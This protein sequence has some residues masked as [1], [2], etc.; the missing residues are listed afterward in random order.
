VIATCFDFDSH[1]QFS[2]SFSFACLLF[3]TRPKLLSLWH[4]V[5]GRWRAV[6]TL[7]PGLAMQG[8]AF[9]WASTANIER[10]LVAEFGW[11]A[12][13]NQQIHAAITSRATIGDVITLA[14]AYLRST[15]G[16]YSL[17]LRASANRF[18]HDRFAANA[19]SWAVTF[20]CHC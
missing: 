19:A 14:L 16:N 7:A 13:A 6:T 9:A 8:S 5:A 2:F 20:S 10:D 18:I 15:S 4:W 1:C 17:S 3:P 11:V 12:S